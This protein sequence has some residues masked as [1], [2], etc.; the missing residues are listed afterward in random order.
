MSSKDYIMVR[1]QKVYATLPQII[2]AALR[3]HP[4]NLTFKFKKVT[5]PSEESL[6]LMQAWGGAITQYLLDKMKAMG[7]TIEIIE[8]VQAHCDT[9]NKMVKVPHH[10]GRHYYMMAERICVGNNCIID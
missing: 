5:T 6:Y 2:T 10:H 8:E 3:W 7:F 4:S 1:G 9:C